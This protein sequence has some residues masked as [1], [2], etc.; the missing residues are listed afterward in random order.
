MHYN[1]LIALLNE[2]MYPESWV[3]SMGWDSRYTYTL[4]ENVIVS[5]EEMP[6]R[7]DNKTSNEFTEKF[8]NKSAS[9]VYYALKYNGSVVKN[10]CLYMVDGARALIPAPEGIADEHV[11]DDNLIIGV[12]IDRLVFET[13]Y[14]HDDTTRY[15]KRSGLIFQESII[16]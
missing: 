9:Y 6:E 11:D 8:I 4:R 14:E 3:K 7:E 1:Q 10:V 16:K 15:L 12:I 13:R 5:I 2:N